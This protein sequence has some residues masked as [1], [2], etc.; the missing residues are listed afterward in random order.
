VLKKMKKQSEVAAELSDRELI[1]NV[2]LT[3]GIM[4]GLALILGLIFFDDWNEFTGLF[5][6]EIPFIMLVGGV[7]ALVVVLIDVILEKILPKSW[8]DD[9]GINERVFR[10]ITIPTIIILCFVIALAEEL[11]FRAVLQ[12][13]FGL[14]IASSLFA[15]I[16]IRYLYKPVL[17]INVTLVSFLLGALFYWTGNVLVTIFTHFLIDVTLGILI[18]IKYQKARTNIY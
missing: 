15:V 18:R 6:L 11:L 2:Y 8:T 7:V 5:R 12:T 3:Q 16:H 10:N 14:V 17:F 4:G 9:G 13:A 1:L